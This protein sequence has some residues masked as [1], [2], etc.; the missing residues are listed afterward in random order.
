ME[1]TYG[2]KEACKILELGLIINSPVNVKNVKV[3][4]EIENVTEHSFLIGILCF[5]IETFENTFVLKDFGDPESYDIQTKEEALDLVQ[6]HLFESLE[7]K[8]KNEEYINFWDTV[9][10]EDE[11]W[12]KEEGL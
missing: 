9:D 3:S 1:D 11:N 4:Y 12:K 6:F 2:I 7:R 5:I 10:V 8:I